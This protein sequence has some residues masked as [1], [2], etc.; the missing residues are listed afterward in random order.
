L[1]PKVLEEF[2][3][4]FDPS[5]PFFYFTRRTTHYEV[6]D[7][8]FKECEKR[9]SGRRGGRRAPQNTHNTALLS[10]CESLLRELLLKGQIYCALL[11]TRRAGCQNYGG[12]K[13]SNLPAFEMSDIFIPVCKIQVFYFFFEYPVSC[14]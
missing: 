3:K 10:Q 1:W 13:T 11:L 4:R 6:S 8:V 7:K 5:C 12:W 2:K 9:F 14:R